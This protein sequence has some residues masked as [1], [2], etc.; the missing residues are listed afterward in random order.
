MPT[1]TTIEPAPEGLL[2]LSQWLSPAFPVSAFAYSHGMEAAELR[3]EEEV[4]DWIVAVLEAGAGRNDAILL[5]LALKRG[6]PV[7]T[8]TDL[9]AA[10]AGS[11]ER[12]TETRDMGAAF[13]RT[14]AEM[15]RD[16]PAT[17]YPVAIGVAARGLGL[18]APLVAR[19][20][21]QSFAG[22]LVSAAQRL[23]PVGQA[24]GQRILAALHPR[25][26]VVADAAAKA[27]PDDLGGAVF[28][29]DLAAMRHETR[30]VR[31]FRT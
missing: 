10:L 22:A 26:A 15:G 4:R 7:E 28:G 20:Y 18:P 27:G 9:A 2:T 1:T 16:V 11:S 6:F 13:A 25:I 8:L 31:L 24:A 5:C 3:D 12:W 21:L 23:V 17:A 19:L 29:A 14:L 30:E